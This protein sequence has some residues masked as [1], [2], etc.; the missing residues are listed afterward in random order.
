MIPFGLRKRVISVISHD[1]LGFFLE[2]IGHSEWGLDV[3][4]PE[5]AEALKQK[6]DEIGSSRGDRV[7]EQVAT[8]QAQVWD[9]TRENVLLVAR[10][11]H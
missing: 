1:K 10:S 7:R 11:L 5:F 9:H 2:D 4:D 6:I 3:Q 8:A